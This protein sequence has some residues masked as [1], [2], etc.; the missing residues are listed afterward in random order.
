SHARGERPTPPFLLVARQPPRQRAG[1]RAT[2]DGAGEGSLHAFTLVEGHQPRL[3]GCCPPRVVGASPG[4][5]IRSLLHAGGVTEAV[6]S[7]STPG[8]RTASTTP[9]GP[10]CGD[11]ASWCGARTFGPA[12]TIMRTRS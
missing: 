8:P 3:H 6:G 11:V 12:T 2:T 4:V 1:C 5:T 9:R 10:C 7:A